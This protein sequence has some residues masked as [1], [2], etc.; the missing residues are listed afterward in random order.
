VPGS[1][2]EI[3]AWALLHP[4]IGFAAPVLMVNPD[5]VEEAGRV[6]GSSSRTQPLFHG[7]PLRHWGPFGGPLWYR[8]VS[9][10]SPVA[11]SVK[12]S[13]WEPLGP[14]ELWPQASVAI[15]RSASR[16]GMRGVVSPHARVFVSRSAAG[17]LGEFDE[18]FAADPFFNPA[19]GSV[20]P[21]KFRSGEW[22]R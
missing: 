6:L 12:R 11:L 14:N 18:S 22:P 13:V 16:N 9:A 2:R 1:I 5:T 3:S 4:Q 19:F 21:L 7:F 17:M 20:V 8:N 10:A 15:C